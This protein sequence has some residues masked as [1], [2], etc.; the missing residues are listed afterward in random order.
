M[1]DLDVV[2]PVFNEGEN[3]IRVLESLRKDVKSTYRVLICYDLD[4]DNTLP[5]VRA[6]PYFNANDIIFVKNPSRGPHAAV[7]AGLK[8]AT[9]N[10]ILVY[11][12]DDDF[13]APIVDSMVAL[14]RKGYD[15]VVASRFIPGGCMEGCALVKAVLVRTASWTLHYLARLP[16]KDA[17]NGLRLFSR[18][19]ISEVPLESTVGFT[20][21]IELLVKAHR[22]GY[23]IAEVPAKWF[24]RDTGESRFKVFKWMIPYLR[25]YFYTFGTL[26][27]RI[28]KHRLRTHELTNLHLERP[29]VADRVNVVD[30]VSVSEPLDAESVQ[31]ATKPAQT[32]SQI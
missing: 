3:I 9:S 2:I 15:V 27:V 23:P 11:M 22:L 25:W 6:W 13:N 20:F 16:V 24:Q 19:L 32:F 29:S 7:V 10:S 30:P 4:S 14:G 17:T 26:F 31:E 21:S 12:A 28:P 8:A 5:R 18:R 1:R